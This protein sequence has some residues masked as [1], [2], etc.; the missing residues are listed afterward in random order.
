MTDYYLDMPRLGISGPIAKA[1]QRRARL[2]AR[3]YL[4]DPNANSASAIG[5]RPEQRLAPASAVNRG[6]YLL[7]PDAT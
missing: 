4:F 5:T 3:E 1:R 2:L 6:C 7:A